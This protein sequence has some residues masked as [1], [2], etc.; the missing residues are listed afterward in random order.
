M[1]QEIDTLL[2]KAKWERVKGTFVNQRTM[3][4]FRGVDVY[5][6][7]S[8]VNQCGRPHY[9]IVCDSEKSHVESRTLS[10]L[11]AELVDKIFNYFYMSA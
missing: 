7:H 8:I 4:R 1:K 5:V 6:E 2:K 9:Y 3:F 11:R 10:E